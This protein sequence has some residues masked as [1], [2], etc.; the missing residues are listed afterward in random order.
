MPP[1]PMAGGA[2]RAPVEGQQESFTRRVAQFVL[3]FSLERPDFLQ[4]H[5]RL[6]REVVPPI[7]AQSN[8]HLRF[9]THPR[10]FRSEKQYGAFVLFCAAMEGAKTRDYRSLQTLAAFRK[11]LEDREAFKL[12]VRSAIRLYELAQRRMEVRLSREAPM[13][14][15]ALA[16]LDRTSGRLSPNTPRSP[17]GKSLGTL[18]GGLLERPSEGLTVRDLYAALRSV[19]RGVDIAGRILEFVRAAGLEV[20]AE[21]GVICIST[22]TGQLASSIGPPEQMGHSERRIKV[23]PESSFQPS[24]AI[25]GPMS[26]YCDG[27]REVSALPGPFID[28]L[29]CQR[30]SPNPALFSSPTRDLAGYEVM[31]SPIPQLSESAGFLPGCLTVAPE[32]CAHLWDPTRMVAWSPTGDMPLPSVREEA[33]IL[34]P[35]P[36]TELVDQRPGTPARDAAEP[37]RVMIH[38]GTNSLEVKEST[39]VPST[40]LPPP[41]R[42]ASESPSQVSRVETPSQNSGVR[43][44]HSG[45]GISPQGQP[46]Y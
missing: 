4:Q 29:A 31:M 27:G 43:P 17:V 39:I 1:R 13:S 16:S 20:S 37:Q 44:Y 12:L 23:E 9:R 36:H 18:S 42:E 34:V 32:S 24:S 33:G 7:M 41:P 45:L 25:S 38:D 30:H 11:H 14:S 15:G 46:S 2:G 10:P 6:V 21:G 5:Q 28:P 26:F 8:H 40:L 22:I 35:P 19:Y 3:S